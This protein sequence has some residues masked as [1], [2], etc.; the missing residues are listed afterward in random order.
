MN[1]KEYEMLFSLNAQLGSSYTGTFTK[2]QQQLVSM[3]KEINE[4]SKSQSNIT[5]YEKQQTAVEATQKKLEMLQRQYD[6]IQQELDETGGKSSA[7]KNQME[8]KQAQIEKTSDALATQTAKLNQMGAALR[9]AGVDTDNLGKESAEL[10]AEMAKLKSEQEKAAES[11]NNFGNSA[12]QAFDA[13]QQ[14]IVAAGV[15]KA[16]KEIYD[17]L[18]D[19][20]RASID[21]ESALTGVEKTTDLTDKELAEMSRA[22][23]D[24]STDIPQTTTE[25][26]AVAEAAGQL[27]IE[28]DNIREFTEIMAMLG[29]ATNM[30]SDEA[31]TMLAQFVSITGMNP[32]YYSNLG[33]TIV[34]L[35]NNYATTEKNIADMNQSIA[36]AGA[37]AGMSEAEISGISAAVTSLGISAQN[38]GTQ[39]TK[40]ISEINSAVSSGDGLEKWAAAA[41]MSADDF[42]AAWGENAA[43]ALDMFIRGLNKTYESGQDVYG[44]LS[45]LGITETRMV[46]MVT[47]LAKSGDRLTD[48]LDT[49]NAAWS[50]NT[51]LTTEAEKRYGTTQSQ[52]VLMQNAYNN[53]KVAIGDNYT[54]ALKDLYGVG[55]DVLKG[56][57]E[58]IEKNPALVKGIT[59]FVGVLGV[60]TVA[61]VGY[62]AATKIA[63]VVS[64][65]FGTASL[66]ALGPILAVVAGV[67][68]LAAIVVVLAER[69]KVQLDASW[70]LTSASRAQ[71]QEL[72]ALNAEYEETVQLYGEASYEAQSLQWRIRDLTAEYENGAKTLEEYKAEHESLMSRYAEMRSSHADTS[73]GINTEQQSVTALINKLGELSATTESAASNQQSILAIINA[74]NEAVP[75]LALS[76]GDVTGA[77][78]GFIEALSAV[79][80]VQAQ[81]A[82]LS[83]QW[84]E[85]VSSVGISDPLKNAKTDA[86]NMLAI[87]EAEWKAA[88]DRK[89]AT[90]T[91]TRDI[92][93]FEY[94]TYD[95]AAL[96]EAEEAWKQVQYYTTA[97][98]D[99]TIAYAENQ[100]AIVELEAALQDYQQTQ[101]DATRGQQELTAVL[102][103]VISQMDTLTVAYNEAYDAALQSVGGQYSL[104]DEAAKVVAISAATINSGLESQTKYWQEY[105]ANLSDLG[106]RTSEI[107]G[108]SEM[109][110]SFADGSAD[111]VNAVAGMKKASDDDL[112]AM[113]TNWQNL[114]KEQ[115]SVAGSL[116]ELETG[117]SAS[118]AA[119]QLELETTVKEMDLGYEAANA[120]RNTIQGYIDAADDMLPAVEAAYAKLALAAN[121]A[122]GFRTEVNPMDNY[123]MLSQYANGSHA[124][125]LDYVPFDGYIAELHKGE[126][127]LTSEEA[128]IYTYA[129]QLL[130]AL[131]SYGAQ[132]ANALMAENAGS[133]SAINIILSPQYNTTG[134][135]TPAQLDAIYAANNENL[136]EL[137][138]EV[139]EDVDIDEAS[140]AAFCNTPRQCWD[141]DTF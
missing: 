18:A 130:S 101:N 54:P 77:T 69:S 104:W 135:E 15:A 13:I 110:A 92:E 50:E 46:T 11:A 64:A 87:A 29:T 140:A 129:P 37:I 17:F 109:L 25:L 84:D 127:V 134:G 97:L 47:S 30:T 31:A 61:I 8:S 88:L 126:R 52:L 32:A 119:L 112:R 14:A 20:A 21:F 49:A 33:A 118:M 116:A 75:E 105:N 132:G 27:G 83:A 98:D 55:T 70:E 125:G 22:L 102:A 123:Y 86:E 34:A 51:A 16:L 65:A 43:G 107:E 4:L 40:L 26:A 111:S 45:D 141:N 95:S 120:G 137:I 67:A 62:T 2:A 133:S 63:T 23:K 138:I 94:I 57:T 114:K 80:D 90:R 71:Y 39:M 24:L 128:Q 103:D 44:V 76:Y 113:V 121:N 5:A 28:K 131:S 122:L 1:R 6:N 78:P 91:V 93:N 89:E 68:A 73:R 48:T 36:A 136:R 74:L 100:A 19:C 79:A 108:L 139:L 58:F 99:A 56:L 82:K 9:E 10:T 96:A 85:Y 72:Q 12:T 35:G 7:L 3:Q 59:A 53:L 115:E 81:Q 66:A 41:K 124:D 38:G 42:S 106:N 117:F 60:A